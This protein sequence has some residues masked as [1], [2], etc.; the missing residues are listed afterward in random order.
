MGKIAAEI[1]AMKRSRFFK[2]NVGIDELKRLEASFSYGLRPRI[3]NKSIFPKNY[4]MESYFLLPSGSNAVSLKGSVDSISE[5]VNSFIRFREPKLSFTELVGRHTGSQK[6]S[7]VLIDEYLKGMKEGSLFSTPDAVIDEMRYFGASFHRYCRR[8]V[9]KPLARIEKHLSLGTIGS[10]RSYEDILIHLD[11]CRK[12]LTKWRLLAQELNDLSPDFLQR[13]RQEYNKVDEYCFYIFRDLIVDFLWVLQSSPSASHGRIE[14]KLAAFFR[15]ENWYG[16]KY[17]YYSLLAGEAETEWQSY[18]FVKAQ[19]RHHIWSPFFL[20]LSGRRVHALQTHLGP[21]IAAA[22][23]GAWAVVVSFFVGVELVTGDQ[24]PFSFQA[25]LLLFVL[26]GA[27]VLKDRM[28]EVG[29][30][31]F[32]RGFFL[33]V[34]DSSHKMLYRVPGMKNPSREV[35]WIVDSSDFLSQR[36][37]PSDIST[38]VRSLDSK[39]PATSKT[40]Q[41]A[42]RF[43][44]KYCFHRS[45]IREIRNIKRVYDFTF[46]DL[47]PFFANS[48][49]TPSRERAIGRDGKIV[50]VEVEGVIKIGLVVRLSAELNHYDDIEPFYSYFIIVLGR[51]GILRIEQPVLPAINTWGARKLESN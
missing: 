4:K 12:I 11:K 1:S 2:L 39:A 29:R 37:L 50:D 44:R 41:F 31:A 17:G 28:K 45:A 9:R 24:S 13:F 38:F 14:K 20:K 15:F 25:L 23:A 47:K 5:N 19:L 8:K 18:L 36:D 51:K 33:K 21:M 27:Y 16:R 7:L 10:A 6:S 34:P 26:T 22:I 42:L 40:D 46:I 48:Q 32:R 49:D 35:G 3:G 30:K 43:S